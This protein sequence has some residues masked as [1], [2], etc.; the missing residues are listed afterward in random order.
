MHR[1]LILSRLVRVR[2]R[3]ARP[4]A[5]SAACTSWRGPRLPIGRVR[6]CRTPGGYRGARPL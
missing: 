5:G 2:G 3:G 4:R 6:R 1:R